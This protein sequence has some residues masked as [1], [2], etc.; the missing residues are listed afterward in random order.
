MYS[1][2]NHLNIQLKIWLLSLLS[3]IILIILVGG[4]TRLTDSGLIYNNLGI[5]CRF[6]TSIKNEKWIDYFELY[7]KI[8]EYKEQNF[9]MSSMNSKLFF[10]GN[11]IHR[12]LGRLIGLVVF[13]P[14]IY[15]T[16]KYGS[17]ILK[18]II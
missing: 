3:L 4:L 10:G 7:K 5:I 13:L 8:P 18:N 1:Q 14:M 12:Q 17:W 15:F 6:F 16:L 11:G 9:N 2:N